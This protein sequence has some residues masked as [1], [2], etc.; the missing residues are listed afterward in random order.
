MADKLSTAYVQAVNAAKKT[1]WTNCVL[2]VFGDGTAPPA[3]ANAAETGTL[4]AIIT[5][6]AGEFVS[7][8]PENG[9][10]FDVSVDGV[11][12]KDTSETWKGYGLAAAGTGITATHF[13]LYANTVVTG[14]VTTTGVRRDGLIGNSASYEWFLTNP[15]ISEGV[16]IEVA[17]FTLTTPRE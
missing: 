15:V 13:R 3:N 16:P 6:S 8:A 14:V 4:L 1:I 9:L 7:G 12:S 5:K 17:T 11:L 10:N 2:H